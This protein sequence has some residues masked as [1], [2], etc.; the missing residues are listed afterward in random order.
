M[1]PAPPTA[2][3]GSSATRTENRPRPQV[4][5]NHLIA[6]PEP[7]RA[8]VRVCACIIIVRY[9]DSLPARWMAE[10]RA[11]SHPRQPRSADMTESSH[12]GPHPAIANATGKRER[13]G[14]TP[15]YPISSVNSVHIYTYYFYKY[16]Y[17]NTR[18]YFYAPHVRTL[19]RARPQRRRRFSSDPPP[20]GF[21]DFFSFFI[22]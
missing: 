8:R 13:G 20:D 16:I 10:T 6:A 7:E 3:T 4:F 21:F 14:N 2:A 17:I 1:T 18:L 11:A 9:H 19:R 12:A 5:G 15:S 22:V